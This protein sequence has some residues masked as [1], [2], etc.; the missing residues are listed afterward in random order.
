MFFK[1]AV[2]YPENG[3]FF[4]RLSSNKNQ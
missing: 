1:E 4:I 2:L 3:F